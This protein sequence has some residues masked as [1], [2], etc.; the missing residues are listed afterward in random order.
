[1]H[2]LTAKVAP[3]NLYKKKKVFVHDN[4]A[5]SRRA[6]RL[7]DFVSVK[8]NRMGGQSEKRRLC[9]NCSS[10]RAGSNPNTSNIIYIVYSACAKGQLKRRLPHC[11]SHR[12]VSIFFHAPHVRWQFCAFMCYDC[13]AIQSAD[14]DSSVSECLQYL[15]S[16]AIHAGGLPNT[17]LKLKNKSLWTPY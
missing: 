4:R 14:G 2:V 17:S 8:H 13:S 9:T 6:L 3:C 11:H 15:K 7:T 16:D 1:M 10:R 5:T 12:S